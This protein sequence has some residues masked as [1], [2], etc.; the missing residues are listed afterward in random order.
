MM[1]LTLQFIRP[2]RSDRLISDIYRGLCPQGCLLMV[3]KVLG[4]E[5]LF[6]RLF[7]KY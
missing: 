5:S 6:N 2:L 3:V 1:I 7:I 4:E